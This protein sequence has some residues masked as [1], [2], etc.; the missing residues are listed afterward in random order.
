VE[1]GTNF[2]MRFSIFDDMSAC[3]GLIKTFWRKQMQP[4]EFDLLNPEDS[5]EDT[6]FETVRRCLE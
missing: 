4:E 2:D 6:R 1:I 5:R 3:V